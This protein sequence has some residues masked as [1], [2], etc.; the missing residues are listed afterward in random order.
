MGGHIV[1][2]ERG[3][4]EYQV[5]NHDCSPLSS[6]TGRCRL[7]SKQHANKTLWLQQS[8]AIGCENVWFWMR[9][10]K[11]TGYFAFYFLGWNKCLN[12]RI[13]YGMDIMHWLELSVRVPT[14]RFDD[15]HIKTHRS[16]CICV[17]DINT[18]TSVQFI[19]SPL[20][21]LSHR[22]F[23]KSW[24]KWPLRLSWTAAAS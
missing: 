2:L 6:T 23:L 16:L 7:T 9:Y 17:F 22:L 3:A 4:G 20:L 19:F 1:W 13:S 10:S 18:C 21:I 8:Q 24:I 12:V 5:L 15:I 11:R 14:D